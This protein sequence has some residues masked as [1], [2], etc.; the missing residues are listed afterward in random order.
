MTRAATASRAELDRRHRPL[1]HRPRVGRGL[2][3]GGTNPP[4]CARFRGPTGGV[5]DLDRPLRA[6]GGK[7]GESLQRVRPRPALARDLRA[8]GRRLT[9][10]KRAP[11]ARGAR[12]RVDLRR[13]PR[14]RQPALSTPLWRHDPARGDLPDR[15]EAAELPDRLLERPRD[16][17]RLRGPRSS[18]I[19]RPRPARSCGVWR[20]LRCPSSSPSSTSR[21]PVAAGS[22]PR[23]RSSSSSRSRRGGGR[24][25]ERWSSAGAASAG[26]VAVLLARDEL[27]D[28]AAQHPLR[29]ARGE[30]QPCSRAPAAS[31][32]ARLRPPRDASCPRRRA[33]AG[34][35]RR[36]SRPCSS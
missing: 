1:G 23:S 36:R 18:S 11:L 27:V 26:A 19:S 17:R 8:R 14:A 10:G 2:L 20:L 35:S 22:R 16:P 15:E 31:P 34:T 21:P 30:A 32:P 4:V 12:H 28:C 33:R 24:Q 25:R 6:L 29:R 5:R 7:S 3:A 9:A 13:P